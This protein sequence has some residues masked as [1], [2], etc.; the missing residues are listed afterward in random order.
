MAFTHDLIVIGSGPGGY[1]AAL[2]ASKQGLNVACVEKGNLGGVCLNI[3]CIPSK[4]LLKS[5]EYA[6]TARHL[7]DYGINVGEVQVDFPKVI[8]R[9]RKVSATSEKGV[10]Y[11]FKKGKIDLHVGTARLT[12]PNAVQVT[13]E[14]E[15]ELSA[16]HIIVATGARPKWFP[17]ME[18]DGEKILTYK[19]AIVRTE[20]PESAVILGAGAIGLEFAY[21]LNAMGTQVTL[22]EGQDRLAPLEDAEISKHLAKSLKKQGITLRTSTFCKGVKATKTG[23]ETTISP[24]GTQ[25]TEV[26]KA[27]MTLLALGVRPNVENIGLE[28]VG[29]ALDGGFIQTDAQCRTSVASIFAIGD[30]AGAPCLAHKASAEA[31]VAV[32]AILGH[33]TQPVD[34]NLIPS[35]IF[36]VPQVASVGKTQE[37][38]EAAGTPF[39]LGKFNF[40]ANGKNRGTGHTEGFV[41]VLVDPEYEEIL[42]AH[43]LGQDATELLSELVLAMATE[44]DGSSFLQA[45]HAHPISG[46]AV[47]EAVAEA[48]GVGVHS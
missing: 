8:A 35:G 14:K 23:T 18:P 7:S 11:L 43:I 28:Q 48:I 3:G 42:G 6:N 13:G 1:V 32:H 37:Q 45:I 30:V 20:Q 33:T 2:L 44:I 46:E 26:L 19:E 5:A 34:P 4:A 27:D 17:G 31:H 9:S 39:K 29:V 16:P 12:G 41:K 25:D 40:A 24:A 21:F 38:L 36:T 22:V 10:K 15:T 47:M